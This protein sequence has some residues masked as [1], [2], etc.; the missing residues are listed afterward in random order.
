M[1]PVL[2]LTNTDSPIEA[3]RIADQLLDQKLAAAVQIMGPVNSRYRW[4]DKIHQRQEWVILIKTSESREEEITS[5]IKELHGYELPGIMKL[6]IEGGESQY[7]QWIVK[8]SN[9]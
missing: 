2:I 3:E 4:Q 1:K 8:Q 9:R 6:S 5:L 7:L